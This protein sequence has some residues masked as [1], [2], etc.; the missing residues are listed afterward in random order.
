[1]NITQQPG[2]SKAIL[3]VLFGVIVLL[4]VQTLGPE[5]IT[6]DVFGYYLYLPATFIHGDFFMDDMSWVSEIFNT[7]KISDTQYQ[8]QISPLG[9]PTSLFLMGMSL[10]YLPFFLIGHLIAIGV[11]FPTDGFSQP[12]QNSLVLG[13]LLYTLI[14]LLYLRKILSYYF[15]PHTTSWVLI[16]I[17]LGTNYLHFTTIKNLETANVLFTLLAIIIWNSIKWHRDQRIGDLLVL[18]FAIA[19][20][21]LIK[22]SE[23]V[24]VL[25][26]LLWGIQS[27]KALRDKW[28]AIKNQGPQF[29]LATITGLLLFVPQMIY[30]KYNTGHFV[31]DSYVNPGI[32]L[33][34]L[35][36]HIFQTLFSFRKGWL[37]YTPIMLLSLI[38][39][40]YLYKGNKK[41]FLATLVYFLTTFYIIS[42]WTEWWYGAGYSLRPIVTA[43]AALAIP[44]AYFVDHFNGRQRSR[45]IL[46]GISLILIGLNLF[47][48]WQFNHYIID[49]YRM[50]KEYYLASFGK[51]HVSQKTKDELLSIDRSLSGIELLD[52][53]QDYL[54]K[55][56][57]SYDFESD[58]PGFNDRYIYD[59]LKNS[60][61]YQLDQEKIY[62]PT[63]STTYEGITLKDHAWIKA[64]VDVLI[65]ESHEGDLPILVL[66]LNREEGNY[67]YRDVQI[68]PEQLVRNKWI[69]LKVD[70]LTPHIRNPKDKF[71]AYVWH[72]GKGNIYIDNLKI[73]ALE[74]KD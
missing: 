19:L 57:G 4:R 65:P 64:S 6:W 31:Y 37:I 69:S 74:P 28:L 24:C 54:S 41:I 26:P 43:Y 34:F 49:P 70:Y 3:C 23:I 29:L 30:W 47:Q 72:R 17:V 42:S 58:D 39:F 12:Y 61:V 48:S 73:Y 25:I 51:T 59:T 10:L 45:A 35:A 66:T 5:N 60:F 52:N 9:K 21:T 32:G 13:F 2:F 63:I 71:L 18:S 14:G 11:G 16:I 15:N 36:P 67:G 40:Y 20:M 53:P 50:T 33:D 62:S 22:P 68:E 38:G 46:I 44:L 55:N 56:I 7:Y 27:R 1:M 8:I